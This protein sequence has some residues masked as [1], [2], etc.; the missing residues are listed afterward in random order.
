MKFNIKPMAYKTLLFCVSCSL[1]SLAIS[2]PTPVATYNFNNSLAANEANTPALTAID[3]LSENKF[4]SDTVFGETRQV[5][6]FNGNILSVENAGL[7]FPSIGFLNNDDAF[8]IEIIFQFKENQSSWENIFGL[9]NRQNDRAFYVQP[10][11]SLQ[12]WP[13]DSGADSFIFGEYHHV[14]LTN[15]GA[16]H[17]TVYIDGVFQFDSTTETVN[18]S[19]YADVNPERL[20]HFFADNVVGGGQNEFSDGR[21]ALIRIYDL[22]LNAQDA[23]D[24]STDPFEGVAGSCAIPENNDCVATYNVDGTLNIPCVSVPDG[25]GGTVMFQVDMKLIPFSTPFSFE[26]T[27]AQ[28]K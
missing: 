5:Y 1:S 24:I 23:S 22:E 16:G 9:S 21:V 17:V 20:I 2:A 7:S 12:V 19:S 13:D 3:P 28:Q 8:S 11:D 27:G 26:L 6:E 15:D 14:T 25:S 18:F 10:N 4:V